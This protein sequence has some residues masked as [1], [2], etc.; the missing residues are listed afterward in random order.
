MKVNIRLSLFFLIMLIVSCNNEDYGDEI[1]NLR[2]DIETIRNVNNLLELKNLL[3]EAKIDEEPIVDVNIQDGIVT[4]LELENKVQILID[5]ELIV[6]FEIRSDD[7]AVSF[8]FNDSTTLDVPYLGSDVGVAVDI[9]NNIFNNSP[10]TAEAYI[11]TPL[12]GLIEM[13]V[14]G[15]D[16]EF[17]DMVSTTSNSSDKHTIEILGLYPDFKNSVQFIL[18]SP[19]GDERLTIIKEITTDPLPDGLPEFEIVKQYESEEQ[20][21]VFLINFRPTGIPF[22]IDRFG[23]IRW[24]STAFTQEG[25]YGLQR[26]QNGNIAYGKSG[27]GQG[28]V[29]EYSMAGKL[30]R[31]Y[32]FYSEYENAHHDVFEMRNGNFLIPVNKVGSATI[33]DYII[34][35]DR[36]SGLT[37]NVWDLNLILPKRNTFINDPVD[38][39]HVNAVVHDERDNSL[40]ISG[41]RQGLFKVSWDNQLK[42]IFA[43]PFGW[44]GYEDYLLTSSDPNM[45]WNWGQHA[46]LVK[47]DGNVMLFDNGYGRAFGTSDK[48]SRALEV[49]ITENEIGGS[50]ETVWEFGRDRGEEF[51][52]PVVSDVDYIEESDTRLIVAGSLALELEYTDKD[53]I[54]NFW[55]NN[56]LKSKIIETDVSKK[57]LFEVNINSEITSSSVYR[58]EKL[59]LY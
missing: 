12:P 8:V 37:T 14:L 43:P 52:A 20:N 53:N 19:E 30:I 27:S 48:F 24:Y 13:R 23:K 6:D 47:P 32:S 49:N 35:V 25:K 50:V 5:F 46:P 18:L 51:Y 28:S 58:A 4:G 44:D 41:Q 55:S 21:V 16:G 45:D 7:W 1:N 9:S 36:N 39:V 54:S 11:E 33:E 38:W 40:I 15:Q 17:S 26:L 2:E 22:M 56:P 29:F 10:L 42:W 34:E 59:K 31:E 3:L 57:I